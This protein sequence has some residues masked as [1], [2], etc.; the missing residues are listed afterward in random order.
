MSYKDVKDKFGDIIVL[1]SFGTTLEDVMSR[2]KVI[3]EDDELYIPDVPVVG[4]DLFNCEYFEMHRSE[5]ESAR[6]LFFDDRSKEIFDDMVD[7]QLERFIP[8]IRLEDGNWHMSHTTEDDRMQEQI[9]I[10]KKQSKWE[11]ITGIVL[12][13]ISAAEWIIRGEPTR[14]TESPAAS[15]KSPSGM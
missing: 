7:F 1:V 5:L 4:E 13:L 10:Y 8:Y 3:A 15:T 14:L 11:T 12:I 2:I 9:A 6:G